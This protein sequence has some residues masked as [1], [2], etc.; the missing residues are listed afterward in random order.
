MLSDPTLRGEY[1]QH[2]KA[3]TA[4]EATFEEAR[5]RSRNDE[6]NWAKFDSWLSSI[7]RDF[8]SAQFGSK[9]MFGMD[10]PT[11]SKS[12]SAWVF[13]IAGGLVG[14]FV[15][16][17]LLV[18][19]LVIWADEFKSNPSQTSIAKVVLIRLALFSCV[20][21]VAAGAWGGKWV[22]FMLVLLPMGVG[23][24]VGLLALVDFPKKHQ[25]TVAGKRTAIEIDLDRAIFNTLKFLR[26]WFTLCHCKPPW[27]ETNR[28]FQINVFTVA[29]ALAQYNIADTDKVSGLG[30]VP[31]LSLS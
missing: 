18:S 2:L 24:W 1:D 11:A 12:V 26:F 30:F 19:I 21:S 13:L 17:V 20:A 14:L 4:N 25:A 3:G 27:L 15:W 28:C 23:S 8:D 10:M 7:S 6:K 5:Q 9:R 22:V 31:E 29:E 16:L